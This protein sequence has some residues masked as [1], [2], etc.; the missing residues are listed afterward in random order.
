MV[1]KSVVTKS[2]FR[3]Q[4]GQKCVGGRG[5]AAWTSLGEYTTL[6]ELLSELMGRGGKE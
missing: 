2:V 6:P 1:T 3:S 4:N 5:A